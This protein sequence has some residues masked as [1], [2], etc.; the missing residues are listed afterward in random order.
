MYLVILI[1]TSAQFKERN[2]NQAAAVT[3]PLPLAV[4]AL[5]CDGGVG[6]GSAQLD[7]VALGDLLHLGLDGLDGLAL[8]VG[9]RQ[10]GLELLVGCDQIL[11]TDSV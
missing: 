7:P 9:L 6:V 8:H 5:R 2:H 11:R 1:T 4:D 10:G 3:Y